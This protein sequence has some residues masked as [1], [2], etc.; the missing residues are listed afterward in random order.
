MRPF[1][2]AFVTLFVAVDILGVLPLYVSLT[3]N[4]DAGSR[5]RLPLQS[6]LTATGVALGFLGLGESLFRLM[7]I[8]VGDFQVA[9]GVLLFLLST[10]DIVSPGTLRRQPPRHLGV[11]PLG[12]PLIA[13]PAALATLVLLVQNYGYAATLT[14]LGANMLLVFLAL[15]QAPRVAVV[16][17]EAGSE[18]IAKVSALFL[19]AFGVSL[20]RRGLAGLW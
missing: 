17:G 1:L 8:S 11:V 4:L 5:R 7:G 9:G 12:T 6:V 10:Y 18:A 16:L 19:A 15:S 13:G 20:V 2:L 3:A 14:A